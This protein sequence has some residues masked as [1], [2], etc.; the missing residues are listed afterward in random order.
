MS[1]ACDKEMIE[2]AKRRAVK[3]IAP[4]QCDIDGTPLFYV[5]SFGYRGPFPGECITCYRDMCEKRKAA[6]RSQ[7]PSEEY[8]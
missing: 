7:G 2:D 8:D 4:Y 6:A 5:D 3:R 1:C